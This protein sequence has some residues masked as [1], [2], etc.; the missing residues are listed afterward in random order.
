MN[1]TAFGAVLV[2]WEPCRPSA[3]LAGLTACP[4]TPTLNGALL[5]RDQVMTQTQDA[6]LKLAARPNEMNGRAAVASQKAVAQGQHALDLAWLV[7]IN[8]SNQSR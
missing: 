1:C 3:G 5:E 8:Q 7:S 2:V 4:F 6:R